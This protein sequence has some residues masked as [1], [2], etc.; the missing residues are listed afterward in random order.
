L[1]GVLLGSPCEST[2]SLATTL[3]YSERRSSDELGESILGARRYPRRG[4]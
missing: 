3:F 4:Q 2:D 1:L